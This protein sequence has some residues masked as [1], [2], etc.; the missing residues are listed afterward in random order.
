MASEL[1]NLK[2]VFFAIFLQTYGL[3]IRIGKDCYL[4]YLYLF[5]ILE[6]VRCVDYKGRQKINALILHMYN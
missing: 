6:I 2:P 1:I 4:Y 3:R 5:G